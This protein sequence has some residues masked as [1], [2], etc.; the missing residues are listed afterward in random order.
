LT[1]DNAFWEYKYFTIDEVSNFQQ[2]EALW[3]I[4]CFW[5]ILQNAVDTCIEVAKPSNVLIVLRLCLTVKKIQ[6]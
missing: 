1:Y 5:K 6:Q 4:V 3:L 2:S